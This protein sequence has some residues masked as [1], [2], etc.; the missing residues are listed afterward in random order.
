M[1]K[2]EVLWSEV[3]ERTVD[4]LGSGLLL[5]SLSEQGKPNAMAIGWASFGIMWGR[6]VAVVMVRPSRFTYECIEAT[7]DF[8]ISVPTPEMEEAVKFCGTRSGRDVDKFA[9]CDFS[10]LAIDE[11][12]SPGIEQCNIIYYCSVIHTNDVLPPELDEDVHRTCYPSG[13]YHRLYYGEIKL[14]LADR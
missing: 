14:V 7:R 10:P 13:D 11:V 2:E 1:A 5:T 3:L 4:E 9:E 12:R 6:P 8:T